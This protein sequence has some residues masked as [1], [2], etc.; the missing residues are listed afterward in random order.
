MVAANI[1]KNRHVWY[2]SRSYSGYT[3]FEDAGEYGV[4][5]TKNVREGE[6]FAQAK[7]EEVMKH[8]KL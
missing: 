6:K 2:Y 4:K 3:A 5:H 1:V 7:K 8:I